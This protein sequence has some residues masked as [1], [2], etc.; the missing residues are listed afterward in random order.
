MANCHVGHASKHCSAGPDVICRESLMRDHVGPT[1]LGDPSERELTWSSRWDQDL[2][3]KGPRHDDRSPRDECK[4]STETPT[5]GN[6][7]DGVSP[8]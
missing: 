5:H 7:P 6:T 1:R 2:S 4:E 3:H 8:T